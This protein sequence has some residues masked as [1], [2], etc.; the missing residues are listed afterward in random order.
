MKIDSYVIARIVGVSQAT[1]SRAFS[2]PD[3]VSESTRKKIMETAK[4]LGYK[5]DRNASALRKRGSNTVLLLY[6]ERNDGH[7]WTR[8]KRNYWIFSEAV[9]SLTDFFEHQ[10]YVFEVKKADSISSIKETEIKDHCDGILVFDFVTE[11]E[12]EMIRSWKIPYV[13]CHRTIHLTA[14]NHSATDNAGGGILQGKYLEEKGCK[15]PVYVM[16]EEDPFSHK[17]RQTGFQSVYPESLV[18]NSEGRGI[19]SAELISHIKNND[20]DG[21]AFVNDMTLVQTVTGLYHEGID[22]QKKYPIVGYD[23]ST[24][25]LVLEKKPASIQIGISQIYRDAAESLLKL[26]K[27]EIESINLVHTPELVRNDG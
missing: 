26:I 22:I 27:G 24:E 17:L 19:I 21:M 1:V 7:Y 16:N 25:L 10:S 9:L 5:P 11:Q 6:L 12:S 15:N 13:L 18:V 23:D 20:F 14:F 8:L 2:N 4:S 3:K